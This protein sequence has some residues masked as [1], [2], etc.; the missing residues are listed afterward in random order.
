M[1]TL[2]SGLHLFH[3]PALQLTV[4]SLAGSSSFGDWVV[5]SR[6]LSSLRTSVSPLDC[7]HA[8]PS[9]SSGTLLLPDTFWELTISSVV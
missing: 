5:S 9:L 7:W 4:L 8:Q 3:S 1:L 6:L 2:T